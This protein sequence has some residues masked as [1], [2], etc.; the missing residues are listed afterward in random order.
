MVQAPRQA[1]RKKGGS[2]RARTPRA[3]LRT[4]SAVCKLPDVAAE[5]TTMTVSH[6]RVVS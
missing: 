6:Q 2:S 5:V 1:L 4:Q 3:A